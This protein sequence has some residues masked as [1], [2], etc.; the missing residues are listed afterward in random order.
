MSYNRRKFIKTSGSITS[1]LMLANMSGLS[2]LDACN[3]PGKI[4]DF[5]IQLYTLRDDMPKDPKGVL[6]Q[7]AGFGYKQIESYEGPNGMFWGMSNIDFK[8][9]M[10]DLGM[11]IVASHADINKDF[12]KKADEAA[13]IGLKYLICPWLGPQKSMD[14][15]KKAADNFN[16]KGEICKSNGIRFAYHNHDYSFKPIDGQ[17]PQDVM[18]NNTDASLVDFELD[19]YWVAT[20]GEDIEAWLKKYK[21]RFRLCHVKDRS[22]TPGTNNSQNS[23]DLG[24]GSINWPSVLKTAKENGMKHFIVEQEYYAGTTPLKAVEVNA[25]YMKSLKI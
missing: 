21:N 13:A 3:K 9:Y 2:L 6:K 10:D 16:K 1:G 25:G 20:A 15:Y 4:G 11:K 19:M 14:D 22:K 18:M 8:K 7:I 23:V 17:L 24:T 5:G 12:E